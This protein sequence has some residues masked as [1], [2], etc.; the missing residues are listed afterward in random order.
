MGAAVVADLGG[1]ALAVAR[2]V[3]EAGDREAHADL[4]R[5]AAA[6]EFASVPLGL[7]LN[8]SGDLFERAVG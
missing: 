1:R 3:E 8:D 2:T 6:D 5:R 7:E 4:L